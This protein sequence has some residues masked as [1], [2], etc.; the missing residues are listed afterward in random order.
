MIFIA[1][2]IAII[3]LRVVT[4]ALFLPM[5]VPRRVGIVIV[6]LVFILVRVTIPRQRFD[7]L[8]YMT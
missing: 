7:K 5:C 4:Y 3:L 6:S 8:M 2:Y 1:E